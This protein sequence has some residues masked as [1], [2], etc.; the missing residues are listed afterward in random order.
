M[1]RSRLT[2]ISL[3]LVS[4]LVL[5]AG[6]S[7]FVPLVDCP[8]CSGAGRITVMASHPDAMGSGTSSSGK[9]IEVECSTCDGKARM[10]LCHRWMR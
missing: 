4:I 9:L 3:S 8:S 10:T 6:A 5:A 7:L 2:W 1:R